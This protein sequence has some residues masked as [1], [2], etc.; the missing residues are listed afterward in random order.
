MPE[1]PWKT[2]IA[3]SCDNPALRDRWREIEDEL[4]MIVARAG[5]DSYRVAQKLGEIAS[6]LRQVKNLTVDMRKPPSKRFK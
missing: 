2:M 1:E 3:I 5:W 4:Y 6:A